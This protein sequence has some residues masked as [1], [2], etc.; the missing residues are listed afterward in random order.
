VS[1]VRYEHIQ[2]VLHKKTGRWIMSRTVTVIYHRH[3][4]IEYVPLR[5]TRQANE[6]VKLLICIREEPGSTLGQDIGYPG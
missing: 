1:P 5:F 3:K 4:P 2:R 6:S